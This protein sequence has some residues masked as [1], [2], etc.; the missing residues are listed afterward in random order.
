MR[1]PTLVDEAFLRFSNLNSKILHEKFQFRLV[2]MRS[3]E[4]LQL[5]VPIHHEM[6]QFG[7]GKF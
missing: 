5:K 7:V 4:V 3:F 1:V 2:G 6:F